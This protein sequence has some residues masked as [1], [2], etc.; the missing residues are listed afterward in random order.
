MD[1]Q[2]KASGPKKF[3]AE[4]GGRKLI[5][6]IGKLAG[7]AHGSC[8]VQYGDTV[9]LATAVINPEIDEETDF[10]PLTVDY[11]E[12]LYAAGKIKGSRFIK[13]EGR[14]SD[15]AVLTSRMVDRS[16]RP[17]FDEKVRQQ[18]QVVLMVLSIDQENDPDLVSLIA[19]SCALSISPIPWKGPIAGVR[20]GM[21]EGE[22]VLNPTC[23]ALEKS[24]FD[25]TIVGNQELV[26]MIEFGGKEIKEETVAAGVEFGHKHIKKII[27]FME[28]IQK[29]VGEEKTEI[30]YGEPNEEEQK[31]LDHIKEIV[32]NTV[33]KNKEK[34]F[35]PVPKAEQNKELELI[36]EELEE[37]LKADN[38]V[39]KEGRA[40]GV[41]MVSEIVDA[42]ACRLIIEENKRPDGRQPDEIRPLSCEVGFLPRTHGSGLFN[43]G[44]TQVLSIVTLGAPGDEQ[45]IE[46]ME[47]SGKKRYMHHY[48]FPGFS[49]GE[50]RRIG[51]PGR[52]EIGHGALAEKAVMPVLPDKESFPYTIRVVSEV[53][54]SNGST[55]QASVC[56]SSLAL[57]DAGVPITKPVAGISIGIMAKEDLS[58][59]KLLTDIQGVEDHIG[60]MDFKVAGTKDG[61]TAMQVDVKSHG[62]TYEIIRAALQKAKAARE[63]ILDVMTQALPAPRPELSQYAPRVVTLR[64]NPE[65]IRDLI[66]TGGKVINK[67][68][69]ETGVDIDIEDDGLVMVTA[70]AGDKL[71]E[72]MEWIKGITHELQAGEV[73]EGTVTQ[74]MAD[75]NTRR[76]IGALVELLPGQ[77]GMVHISQIAYEHVEKVSDKL[78]VGDKVKVKV[79][80]VDNERGR[81]E[82]SMKAL[83]APPAGTDD[84]HADFSRR[85]S[86]EPRGRFSRGRR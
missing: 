14:P 63:K 41:K 73:Y 83:L 29:E 28:S 3:E 52:R 19:A 57:M 47:V 71:D 64:I 48:N 61:I 43:R 53:L 40:K 82:L 33:E 46:G 55:S 51:S 42:E 35:R 65:K 4:I 6:E 68:I 5:V 31:E 80:N 12:R 66:G 75:R 54:S 24:D 79:M 45:L 78:K 58:D 50:V 1:F 11:E 2:K 81:V 76:E 59:Y 22:W 72:A 20:V 18:V 9:A 15:E 62:I 39:S 84:Y 74:I 36:K 37:I 32:T 17:F 10:F 13:R 70:E 26:S 77:D 44:E 16:I 38:K 7:Q 49:V 23:L 30:E 21:I 56:G 8:T 27:S 85:P 60:G 67:I 25:L 69:D 34:I 86:R